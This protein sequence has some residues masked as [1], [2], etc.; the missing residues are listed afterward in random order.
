MLNKLK[1]LFKK[2]PAKQ[3]TQKPII[4]DEYDELYY[5]LKNECLN[6]EEFLKRYTL[7]VIEIHSKP[8]EPEFIH[9]ERLDGSFD[10]YNN[11]MYKGEH[12]KMMIIKKRVGNLLQTSAIK[13]PLYKGK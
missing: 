2:Q 7:G 3:I 4:K 1:F 6:Q 12:S 10:N 11:P 13:N 9:R 5:R 8:V